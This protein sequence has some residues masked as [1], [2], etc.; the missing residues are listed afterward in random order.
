MWV[1]ILKYSDASGT[2]LFSEPT[3]FAR[4]LLLFL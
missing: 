2:N 4:H 3:L 1:T